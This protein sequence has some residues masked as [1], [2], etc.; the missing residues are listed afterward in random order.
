MAGFIDNSTASHQIRDSW[1]DWEDEDEGMY[2]PI[3]DNVQLVPNVPEPSSVSQIQPIPKQNNRRSFRSSVHRLDRL[4]SRRRQKFQN[5]QAG[6]KIITDIESLRKAQNQKQAEKKPQPFVDAAA[7][8]AIASS[9]AQSNAGATSNNADLSPDNG[10]IQIGIVMSPGSM[11]G[12]E[13]SPHTA[14]V[15]TPVEFPQTTAP[16]LPQYP[17][18][19]PY[20]PS[21]QP[22]KSWLPPSQQKSVWSPDTPDTVTPFDQTPSAFSNQPNLTPTNSDNWWEEQNKF[23]KNPQV[24]QQSVPRH[25]ASTQAYVAQVP[26]FQPTAGSARQSPRVFPSPGLG[27]ATMASSDRPLIT[28]ST[29]DNIARAPCSSETIKA[30]PPYSPSKPQTNAVR[31]QAVFPPDHPMAPQRPP[32]P[33]QISPA[34]S[35]NMGTRGG[36]GMAD[37]PLT[38]AAYGPSAGHGE[39]YHAPPDPI[40][41]KRAA[42]KARLRHEKEERAAHRLGSCWRGRGC[43]PSKGCFGRKGREGRQRRRV[44]LLVILIILIVVTGAIVTGVLLSRRKPVHVEKQSIWVNVTGFPPMPTGVLT[45]V[46]PDND[47]AINTCT[48]P[49]TMWSCSLPKEE[50]SEVLPFTGYQ[51]T[52]TLNIQYDNG[53]DELWKTEWENSTVLRRDE[54]SSDGTSFSPQPAPPSIAE[55]AFLGKYTDNVQSSDKAGEPTPFYIS[56]LDMK[57]NA[58]IPGASENAGTIVVKPRN[59]TLPLP[60]TRNDGSAANARLLPRLWQQPVRLFDR[61][62]ATEHYGF[63]SYFRR[64]IYVQSINSSVISPAD[65][66]GGALISEADYLVTWAQTRVKVA[67]WTNMGNTTALLSANSVN[68]TAGGLQRPGSMPYPASVQLDTHGGNPEE[69]IVWAW[70]VSNSEIDTSETYFIANDIGKGGVVVNPRGSGNA[71]MGGFDGGV[72]GCKCEWQNFLAKSFG[73]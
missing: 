45:V 43:I 11:N 33:G 17:T 72:G 70:G 8:R 34:F 9:S 63:Y 20:H 27:S 57:D 68:K 22:A 6:I 55:M 39:F 19:L 26:S 54:Y 35:V 23:E 37:I 60:A 41:M 5:E 10:R 52:V 14:V 61:G 48:E 38:P 62:L 36:A 32:S 30:P 15:G 42:E 24:Q 67:L 25:F 49:S 40:S 66:N 4:K 65:A 51:P 71:S 28:V 64:T 18:Y 50:Q 73:S 29:T 16:A 58:T 13:I 7:L 53:T 12:R 59:I 44:W 3:D 46:G 56:M 31:Y 69:K 2:T 21:Q 47:V 1:E